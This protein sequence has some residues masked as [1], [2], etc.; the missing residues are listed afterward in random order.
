METNEITLADY[1]QMVG[2]AED[3]LLGKAKK[4]SL[5]TIRQIHWLYLKSIGYNYSEIARLYHRNY[6]AISCGV[7]TI[8]NLIETR[9]SLVVPHLDFIER[10]T[11]KGVA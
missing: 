1:S 8:K 10:I 2:M 7:R 9:D 3:E 11:K 5:S 6:W 4:G